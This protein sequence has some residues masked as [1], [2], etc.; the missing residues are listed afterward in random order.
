MA[1]SRPSRWTSSGPSTPKVRPRPP[2]GSA[3]LARQDQGLA[4][5]AVARPQRLAGHEERFA[6]PPPRGAGQ[7][8]GGA[9]L[10]NGGGG[11]V[12]APGRQGDTKQPPPRP[13]PPGPGGAPPTGTTPTGLV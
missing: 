8:T 10:P 9:Q 1:T 5:T 12:N 6:G 4:G 3:R 11:A 7:Q 13:P 2:I